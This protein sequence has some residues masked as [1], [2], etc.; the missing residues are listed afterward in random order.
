MEYLAA[1]PQQLGQVL[2]GFRKLRKLTQ[3]RA[4]NKGGLLPKTVYSLEA[5]PQRVTVE[6]LFKLLSALDIEIVLR[7]KKA[8]PNSS[9]KGW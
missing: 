1:T 2:R 5:M 8:S 4:G 6:S 7:D 9:A 3:L